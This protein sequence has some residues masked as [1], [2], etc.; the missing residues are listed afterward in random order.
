MDWKDESNETEFIDT[1][2]CWGDEVT[3]EENAETPSEKDE[4]TNNLSI[5]D[6]LCAA[7]KKNENMSM[8]EEIRSILG[9]RHTKLWDA[10]QEKNEENDTLIC[11][12][13]KPH[14]GYAEDHIHMGFV[15]RI[16]KL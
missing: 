16:P 3:E 9:N 1:L 14:V 4:K 5:F 15:P 8:K 6:M 12:K 10:I 7:H 13:Q 2:P 11:K